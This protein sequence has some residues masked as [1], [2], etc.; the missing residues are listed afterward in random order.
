MPIVLRNSRL[1]FLA[2]Q[3]FF[4]QHWRRPRTLE[5][6]LWSSPYYSWTFRQIRGGVHDPNFALP[7]RSSQRNAFWSAYLAGQPLGGVGPDAAW[8]EMVPLRLTAPGRPGF[9]TDNS[10]ERTF[11]DIYGHPHGLVVALTVQS[12][13]KVSETLDVWRDRTRR[14][15]LDQPYTVTEPGKAARAGLKLAVALSVILEWHRLAFYGDIAEIFESGEPLTFGAVIQG[16]GVEP[17]LPI[18]PDLHRT[19]HA[20]TDWPQ[21]WETASLPPLSDHCLPVSAANAATGDALYATGRGL[22]LWR[23]GLFTAGQTG[24]MDRLHTLSCLVHN[25]LAGAVQA[26]SLRLFAKGYAASADAK[27]KLP[28]QF[29]K[30]AAILLDRLRRGSQTYRASSLK[31]VVENSNSKAEVNALLKQ[32]GLEQT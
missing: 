15:R 13:R 21:H 3:C 16:Q 22:T 31:Y 27:S 18:S 20:V 1:S 6:T 4:E 12:P 17:T 7:W 26:E 32:Y 5:P 19:L 24:K 11:Y 8:E 14:L 23:P 25:H 10:E 28:T 9:A 30:R 29:P 2:G